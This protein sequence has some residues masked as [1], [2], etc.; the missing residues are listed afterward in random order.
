MEKALM[1]DTSYSTWL[2]SALADMALFARHLHALRQFCK[3]TKREYERYETE[4]IRRAYASQRYNRQSFIK[5]IRK[6]C[7]RDFEIFLSR[8]CTRLALKIEKGIQVHYFRALCKGQRS[9]AN[10]DQFVKVIY[11]FLVDYNQLQCARAHHTVGYDS[12]F[13]LQIISECMLSGK[14]AS[15]R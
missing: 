6:D 5:A 7:A 9:G 2:K 3:E 12:E 11:S 8:E 15:W 13:I 4:A 14:V 1:K 10:F